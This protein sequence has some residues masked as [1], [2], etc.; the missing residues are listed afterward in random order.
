VAIRALLVI[1]IF[2]TGGLFA[3][4]MRAGRDGRP[5]VP[6]LPRLD[7]GPPGWTSRDYA[8]SAATLRTLGADAYVN[9]VYRRT[10]GAWVAVFVGYFGEQRVNSQIHSPRQCVPG[11]GWNVVAHEAGP[12][13]AAMLITE[14]SR[15]DLHRM[16]YWFRTR[17]GVLTG[18]YALK[19]D[20]VMNS[21]RSRPTDAAFIRF[22]GAEEDHEAIRDLMTALEPSLDSVLGEVGL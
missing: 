19:W 8:M 5:A 11:A 13:A 21:F 12:R 2:G 7:P 10:D 22:L 6:D 3:S 1:L 9:R 4:G 18:E 16:V 15:G 20:L 17:S 14:P